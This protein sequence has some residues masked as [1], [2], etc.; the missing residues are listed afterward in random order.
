MSVHRLISVNGRD[1]YEHVAVAETALG[2]RLPKGAHVHHIDENPRNNAPSNLVICQSAGYHKLLHLR[3]RIVR[4]GG[5]PDTQRVCSRCRR[6]KLIAEFS[7]NSMAQSGVQTAC[8][9][10]ARDYWSDRKA[11]KARAV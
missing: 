10:C 3:A 11:R 4:A 6:V 1:V 7:K 9:A 2:R 5:D 8:R